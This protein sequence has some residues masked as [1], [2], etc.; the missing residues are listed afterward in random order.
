MP[1]ACDFESLVIEYS[2]PQGDDDADADADDGN[3]LITLKN[4][5]GKQFGSTGIS[6]VATCP[7]TSQ[8]VWN[9]LCGTSSVVIVTMW[10]SEREKVCV[11]GLNWVTLTHSCTLWE[12]KCPA[13]PWDQF[14]WG[15][16]QHHTNTHTHCVYLMSTTGHL[17]CKCSR[18][19]QTKGSDCHLVVAQ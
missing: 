4:T 17:L 5:Y 10:V 11:T 7:L 2:R 12:T 13:L 6:L 8:Y 19:R 15:C 3:H 1:E 16:P 18:S 9:L 14:Q